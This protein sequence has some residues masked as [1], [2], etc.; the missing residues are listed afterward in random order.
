VTRAGRG[1]VAAQLCTLV[2]ESPEI[3]PREGE[4]LSARAAKGASRTTRTSRACVLIDSE[5]LAREIDREVR[6][7]DIR[8]SRRISPED[9]EGFS[10]N[11]LRVRGPRTLL[12]IAAR[13]L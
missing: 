1:F 12:M 8:W 9:V 4:A 3:R 6:V 11:A 7:K 13:E 5:E 2:S 10:L